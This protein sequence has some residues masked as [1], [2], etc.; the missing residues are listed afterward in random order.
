[1]APKASPVVSILV[2]IFNWDVS[3]LARSLMLEIQSERLEDRVEI[4]FADDCS[5]AKETQTANKTVLSALRAGFVN[6]LELE[7]NLGRAAIRNHLV[8]QSAGEFL[9]FLDA[10]I[11]PDNGNFLRRYL[12]YACTNSCDVVCGGISYVQRILTGPEYDFYVYMSSRAGIQSAAVRNLRPWRWMFTSNI[13]VRRAA[14]DATP[15]DRRFT[16]YG[17]EDVEWSI[18]LARQ[19]R[20]LHIDNPV[21]HLGLHEPHR[22]LEDMRASIPNYHLL[23]TTHPDTFAQTSI[24]PM[25][26]ILRWSPAWA[27]RAL[28]R[29]AGWIFLALNRIHP[30]AFLLFQFDKAILLA[31]AFQRPIN[32]YPGRND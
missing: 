17:Y 3:H 30:L 26:H 15:F 6:Y 16:G 19:F 12:E 9:L 18:R 28:D 31:L 25:V 1:M 2:P 13:M 23:A 32:R 24:S 4:I 27:L 7:R 11:V 22:V 8:A 14:F 21:S 5:T 29:L 20:V 10:D